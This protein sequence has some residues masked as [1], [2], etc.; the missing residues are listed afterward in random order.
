MVEGGCQNVKLFLQEPE[1]LHKSVTICV[2]QGTK[3]LEIQAFFLV[4]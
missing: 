1:Y 4:G 2:S 3:A